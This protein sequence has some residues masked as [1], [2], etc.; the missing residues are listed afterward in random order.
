MATINQSGKVNEQLEPCI[1]VEFENGKNVE[2]L[3]DT[4]FSSSLCLPRS[5]M[6]ELRLK[7]VSEEEVFGIGSHKEVVD[8]AI[9]NIIWFGQKTEIEV[10]I[11]NGDDRLLGSE[12]LDG[13]ILKI[14]YRNKKVSITDR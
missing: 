7:K 3:I 14:N 12:L 11:N 13:K 2:L 4:G 9:T 10:L 6:Q 1:F 8:V 5:L